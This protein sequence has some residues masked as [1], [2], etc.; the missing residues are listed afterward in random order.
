METEF[1]ECQDSFPSLE[2][3]DCDKFTICEFLTKVS[4]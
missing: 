1:E 2:F 4:Q 3:T